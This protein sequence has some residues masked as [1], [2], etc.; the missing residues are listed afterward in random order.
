MVTLKLRY[1][2]DIRRTVCSTFVEAQACIKSFFGELGNYQLKYVDEDGDHVTVTN[3]M[4]FE[5]AVNLSQGLL[6]LEIFTNAGNNSAM[7]TS[8]FSQGFGRQSN[9]GLAS[10]MSGLSQSQLYQSQPVPQPF[11]VAQPYLTQSNPNISNKPAAAPQEQFA[12]LLA[13]LFGTLQQGVQ[14]GVQGVPAFATG[15]QEFA[16]NVQQGVNNSSTDIG[17]F[18][19]ELKELS[20][21]G[22]N[23]AKDRIALLAAQVHE[24]TLLQVLLA[25]AG[26]AKPELKGVI[27]QVFAQLKSLESKSKPESNS[28]PAESKASVETVVQE[29]SE[30]Q[31]KCS[32]PQNESQMEMDV[33]FIP[34]AAT[35]D[36]AI[37][38]NII[39]DG[40]GAHPIQG[41]RFKCTVCADFDLCSACEEKST[42][43]VNHPMLKLKR[44]ANTRFTNRSCPQAKPVPKPAPKAAPKP[45]P[46]VNRPAKPVARFVSDETCPDGTSVIAGCKFL[47]SWRLRN[48]GAEPF[49]STTV[50]M[51]VGGDNLATDVVKH[52]PVASCPKPGEEVVVTVPMTAPSK[53]GRYMS[54]WRLATQDGTRF[55]QRVWADILCVEPSPVVEESVTVEVEEDSPQLQ[56]LL[57]MGFTD[58]KEWL[59]DLLAVNN[60]D[61]LKCVQDLLKT[62]AHLMNK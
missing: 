18:F 28:K 47:K 46:V 30:T 2:N 22:S 14:Q 33:N 4:E 59:K 24:S 54:Y 39:C 57:A 52:V 1:G 44:P 23:M 21:Q 16:N 41:N 13:Q 8:Q 17:K 40:C 26:S 51:F 7:N 58:N 34:N 38:F 19:A 60:N 37:H 35:G 48:E 49:P 53:P 50:L 20:E 5:E 10:S 55:G 3:Q 56:Q 29:S 42:H 32:V 45:V 36:R 62:P 27:D 31:S 61:V 15:M 11:P 25:Q 43:N 6:K 12:L 9:F